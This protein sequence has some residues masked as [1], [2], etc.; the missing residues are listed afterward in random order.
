MEAGAVPKEVQ[1]LD[2][3][4]VPTKVSVRAENT[5]RD[6]CTESPSAISQFHWD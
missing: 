4:L 5:F 1:M 6:T 2:I 3:R